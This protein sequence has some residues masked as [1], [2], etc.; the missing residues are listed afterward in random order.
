MPFRAGA[1]ATAAAAR[2]PPKRKASPAR[3]A[4]RFPDRT[5][6]VV[7]RARRTRRGTD[8][9]SRRGNGCPTP[10]AATMRRAVALRLAPSASDVDSGVSFPRFP[11]Q[12][13]RSP[14]ARS[15]HGRRCGRSRSDVRRF[16][17]RL[18]KHRP[19]WGKTAHPGSQRAAP[20]GHITTGQTYCVNSTLPEA[21]APPPRPWRTASRGWT[22]HVP[23]ATDAIRPSRTSPT[24]PE[25][26]PD[27]AVADRRHRHAQPE[28]INATSVPN[29]TTFRS[30]GP[31]ST[32]HPLN[33][34]KT[35]DFLRRVCRVAVFSGFLPV[36]RFA[37]A[38]MRR[39]APRRARLLPTSQS[40][41]DL[42]RFT[43]PGG[44]AR[45]CRGPCRFQARTKPTRA[46]AA[47]S[48]SWR[49]IDSAAVCA[50]SIEPGPKTTLGIPAAL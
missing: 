10:R 40:Q 20:P 50:S 3:R 16:W 44:A 19:I 18:T 9:G 21:A 25:P 8:G 4:D 47:A 45:R 6:P 29:G 27:N 35:S 14:G 37:P 23:H 46:A 43:P 13:P 34:Q 33:T 32:D 26:S 1:S 15:A 38:H 42:V 5:M 17:D 2:T 11:V 41:L 24:L 36:G 49:A 22:P 12:K 31:K 39:I 28:S 30:Q 48:T 7:R